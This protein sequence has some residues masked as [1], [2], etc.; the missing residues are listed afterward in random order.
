MGVG[1]FELE[2]EGTI[3]LKAIGLMPLAMQ[4]MLWLM[5]R[6]RVKLVIEA[7]GW[8]TTATVSEKRQACGRCSHAA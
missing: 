7:A 5:L 4:V 2:Q 8:P 3:I 6:Q 1:Q